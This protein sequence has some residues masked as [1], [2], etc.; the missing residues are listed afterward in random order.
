M[1][2]LRGHRRWV[3]R[4][5]RCSRH[6]HVR[7]PTE[8]FE[9]ERKMPSKSE[10]F[11]LSCPRN[12][13][14]P[15]RHVSSCQSS[16]RAVGLA[17]DGTAVTYAEETLKIVGS[18]NCPGEPNAKKGQP[19]PRTLSTWRVARRR[20]SLKPWGDQWH[21]IG[22]FFSN[23]GS[24]GPPGDLTSVRCADLMTL[25]V[26][27]PFPKERLMYCRKDARQQNKTRPREEGERT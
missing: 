20:W 14:A 25:F 5:S 22:L 3:S 17:G 9:P 8:G 2:Q 7:R 19:A 10:S 16:D 23:T 18:R 6:V 24:L 26:V 21:A 11:D 1:G 27:P 13:W 4:G 12:K 15:G